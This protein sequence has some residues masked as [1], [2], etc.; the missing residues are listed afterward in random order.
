MC[1]CQASTGGVGHDSSQ[2]ALTPA[3]LRQALVDL[4]AGRPQFLHW[5]VTNIRGGNVTAGQQTTPYR[6][7]TCRL[8]AAL[9]CS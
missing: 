2:P 1:R 9:R 4:D 3:Y 5:L 6:W 8:G 7:C